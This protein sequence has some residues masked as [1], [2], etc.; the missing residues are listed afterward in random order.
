MRLLIKLSGTKN[1][2]S[3]SSTPRQV[4]PTHRLIYRAA[5]YTVTMD[6]IQ[7]LEPENAFAIACLSTSVAILPHLTVNCQTFFEHVKTKRQQEVCCPFSFQGFYG[8]LLSRPT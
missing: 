3:S 1:G 6:G 8:P 2:V 7:R 4:K 5:K